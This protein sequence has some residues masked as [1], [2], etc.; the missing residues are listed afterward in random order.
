MLILRTI[1]SVNKSLLFIQ[2]ELKDYGEIV[3][4]YVDLKNVGGYVWIEFRD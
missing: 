2:A 1:F 4:I 3:R